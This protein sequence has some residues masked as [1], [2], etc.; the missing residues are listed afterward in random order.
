MDFFNMTS[1]YQNTILLSSKQRKMT[2]IEAYISVKAAETS[3]KTGTY[4]KAPLKSTHLFPVRLA[5]FSDDKFSHVTEI[6]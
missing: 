3:F 6:P 2:N 4:F 5:V 1:L